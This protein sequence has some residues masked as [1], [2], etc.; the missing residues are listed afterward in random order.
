MKVLQSAMTG[1]AASMLLAFAAVPAHA[2]CNTNTF[3]V[4]CLETTAANIDHKGGD[5]SECFAQSDGSGLA[6]ACA[7]DDK[8]FADSEMST[9]GTTH[10]TAK[11]GSF[12]GAFADHKGISVSHVSGA[13][14][15]GDATADDKGTATTNATG[16]SEAHTQA[17]GKCNADATASGAGSFANA[18]CEHNGTHATANATGGGHAE[19]FDDKS[20]ICTPNGGTA[21][22]RSSHGKCG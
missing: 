18:V 11:G 22:V 6:K 9:G 21:R 5:G 19:A 4:L 14:G 17:F 7:S 3:T 16:G 10:A 13:G 1:F 20:P 8:S 2:K 15:D 12:S